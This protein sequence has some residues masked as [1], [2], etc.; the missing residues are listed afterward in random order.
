[1]LFNPVGHVVHI[2]ADLLLKEFEKSMEQSFQEEY[3]STPMDKTLDEFFA[4]CKLS[5]IPSKESS[6]KVDLIVSLNECETPKSA[7]L[8]NVITPTPYK[9]NQFQRSPK[10]VIDDT[11]DYCE[12]HSETIVPRIVSEDVDLRII[13]PAVLSI[14][15][16]Y[17]SG[18]STTEESSSDSQFHELTTMSMVYPDCGEGSL[19]L[20][21]KAMAGLMSD[22]SKAVH[23]LN[24]DLFIIDFLPLDL[25]SLSSS[26]AIPISVAAVKMLSRVVPNTSDPDPF[27]SRPIIDSRYTF[28]EICQLRHL[29]FDSLRR[30]K[31]SSMMMLHYLHHPEDCSYRPKCSHCCETI[32]ELRW[33]CEVC[34]NYDICRTCKESLSK[35]FYES[36]NQKHG[37]RR[38]RIVEWKNDEVLDCDAHFHPHP[39]TPYRISMQ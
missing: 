6:S 21:T 32:E 5:S 1:M 12:N 34:A 25:E 27:T 22:L 36:S 9:V 26:P 4:I 16:R 2:Q 31:Y 8:V 19:Q 10:S 13:S 37:N 11:E 30:A 35:Q 28:L 33:H 7:D 39:L 3:T 20:S 18:S 17:S 29:Q 23:R 14:P 38:A 15:C 24:D